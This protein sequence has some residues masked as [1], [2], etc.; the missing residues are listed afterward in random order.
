MDL[1]QDK[2][3]QLGEAD[4]MR[5]FADVI[6]GVVECGEMYPAE[7]NAEEIES[8]LAFI[9]KHPD[10]ASLLGVPI[11][12]P[13][14]DLMRQIFERSDRAVPL[15]AQALMEMVTHNQRLMA[16]ILMSFCATVSQLS[17]FIH[18]CVF[19][20]TFERL[21]RYLP[22]GALIQYVEMYYAE[23]PKVELS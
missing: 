21:N 8:V 16:Q 1:K 5:N 23:N 20:R 15:N 14:V 19:P 2:R 11:M 22:N 12:A 6:S 9:A 7:A 17:I 18:V 10:L 3:V 4:F 13:G